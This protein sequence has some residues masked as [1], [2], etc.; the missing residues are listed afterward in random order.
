MASANRI[1]KDDA[2]NKKF[3]NFLRKKGKKMSKIEA[4]R[5]KVTCFE[6]GKRGQVKSECPILEKKEKFKSKN[7]KRVKRAYVSWDDHEISLFSDEDHASKTLMAF[8]HSSDEEHE[9]SDYE[10]D[11][12]TSYD[13][14]QSGFNELYGEF[15]KLSRNF[16]NQKKTILKLEINGNETKVELNLI[17]NSTCSHCSSLESKIVELNQVTMKFE[18]CQIDLENVLSS[19]KISNDKYGLG[20]TSLG[21][22]S[23]SQT[24][25]VKAINKFNKEE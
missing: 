5:R 9:I 2:L 13:E 12:R 7:Y 21:K 17:K 10:I 11:D 3:E 22:P 8:H 18:K 20:F 25:F 16:S 4:P 19:Q 24:I 23:T 1:F 6:C 15:L 14:L